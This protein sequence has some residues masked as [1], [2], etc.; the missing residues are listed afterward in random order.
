MWI[1]R[2]TMKGKQ[3]ADGPFAPCFSGKAGEGP[4]LV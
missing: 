2:K 1:L 4:C 3:G